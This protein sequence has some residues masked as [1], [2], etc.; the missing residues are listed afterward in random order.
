MSSRSSIRGAATSYLADRPIGGA[1]IRIPLS[2]YVAEGSRRRPDPDHA[3]KTT[4]LEAALETLGQ[5]VVMAVE[6]VVA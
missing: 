3:T 2:S 5:R 4:K 1:Y 6:D